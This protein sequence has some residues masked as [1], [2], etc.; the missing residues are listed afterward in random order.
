MSLQMAIK[1]L[2]S[3]AFEISEIKVVNGQI[4]D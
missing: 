3:W 2:K 1:F 4:V